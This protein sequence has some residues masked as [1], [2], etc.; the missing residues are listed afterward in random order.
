MEIH[1]KLCFLNGERR[2]G[3]RENKKNE[4]KIKMGEQVTMATG[5]GTG[6]QERRTGNGEISVSINEHSG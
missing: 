6:K 2:N 5:N 3:E 4:N 1:L